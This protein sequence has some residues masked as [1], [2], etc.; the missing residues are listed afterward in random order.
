AV[1]LLLAFL[2]GSSAQWV[3]IGGANSARSVAGNRVWMDVGDPIRPGPLPRSV[4]DDDRMLGPGKPVGVPSPGNE[5]GAKG[6][7]ETEAD[8]GADDKAAAGRGIDD[9]RIVVRDDDVIRI[10]RHDFDERSMSDDNLCVRAQVAV[11]ISSLAFVLD[12]IHD[13]I[14]LRQKR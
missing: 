10:H 1:T 6:D 7:T 11:T 9:Q 13:L 3:I 4:V 12:G 8:G 2:F 14:A 5:R